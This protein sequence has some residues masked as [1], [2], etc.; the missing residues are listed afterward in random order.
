MKN[1]S[2]IATGINGLV[3]SR[4]AQ[5]YSQKYQITPLDLSHPRNPV[6]ITNYEQVLQAFEYSPAEVVIHLAA[7]TN[8]DA[9]WKQKG[10]KDG[11]AYQVNVVGTSNIIKACQLTEKH[12]IHISTA[13]VF[14]GTSDDLYTED[15]LP[16]PIEWYG[17]TKWEAE[18]LVMNSEISWSILRIDQPFRPDQ[19]EK[20]D[21]AHKIIEHLQADTLSPQFTNQY[22]GPTY[23]DDF[24][25]VL[26]FFTR[27]KT[28][29][30]FH[31]SS[32]EKWTPYEFALLLKDTLHLPG[33]VKE[34]DLEEYLKT[35][36]RPYQKNT[37]LN[38]NK[39]KN[40]VD[41]QFEKIEEAI[42]KIK[43]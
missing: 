12:L 14:D 19:F 37:A 2:L 20:K 42:K 13:Y 26:D 11:V 32:G 29:G 39:I 43:F 25:K 1:S 30:L 23:I 22:F 18:Q 40:V 24:A 6:D 35:L 9:A 8:V 10:N 7:F 5:L 41:F 34:G 36:N 4:F 15:D 27:T 21:V 16:N 33:E 3:G 31:A 38:C 17:Q 28:S